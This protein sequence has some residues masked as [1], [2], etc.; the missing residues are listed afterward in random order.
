VRLT[1]FRQARQIDLE[2][3]PLADFAVHLDVAALLQ[4]AVD[5]GQP[6]SRSLAD[7]LGR[8]ERF[9]D[10]A[11]D[12]LIHADARVGDGEQH[13]AARLDVEVS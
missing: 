6:H 10:V 5:G 4:D 7:L 9:E 13:V 12:L 8:E 11:A 3:R 2:R 1:G